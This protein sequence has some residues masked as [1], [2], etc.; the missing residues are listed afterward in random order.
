MYTP[1][2]HGHSYRQLKTDT[3]GNGT[4]DFPLPSCFNDKAE[5]MQRNCA[6]FQADG[7][8][9][10]KTSASISNKTIHENTAVLQ[11]FIISRPG[12]AASAAISCAPAQ[13]ALILM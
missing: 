7:Q 9:A 12:R 2:R 4:Y 8:E 5:N 13:K 10:E 6:C 11:R 1:E 3:T